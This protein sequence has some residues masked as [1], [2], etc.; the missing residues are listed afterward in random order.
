MQKTADSWSESAFVLVWLLRV[1][2][3]IGWI[4]R[5]GGRIASVVWDPSGERVVLAFQLSP[6]LLVCNGLTVPL[7]QLV[8]SGWIAGPD[9][10]K[11]PVMDICAATP[12]TPEVLCV[13]ES[14][15]VLFAVPMQFLSE[16]QLR[17]DPRV[18]IQYWS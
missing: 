4:F 17:Q 10:S 8:P 6:Y 14:T 15:Q 1:S 2:H 12:L 18:L 9:G 3:G 5:V 16:A 13:A 11:A 7:I